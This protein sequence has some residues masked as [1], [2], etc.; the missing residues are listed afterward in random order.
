MEEGCLLPLSLNFSLLFCYLVMSGKNKKKLRRLGLDRKSK[1]QYTPVGHSLILLT[2]DQL[3]QVMDLL[4]L[5]WVREEDEGWEELV[6]DTLGHL[7]VEYGSIDVLVDKVIDFKPCIHQ[8][9]EY[10]AVPI[11]IFH[12]EGSEEV[13][14][15]FTSN[16]EFYKLTTGIRVCED[17]D[18]DKVIEEFSKPE[19]FA[20]VT[21]FNSFQ[22]R[23]DLE[24]LQEVLPTT[25]PDLDQLILLGQLDEMFS[26]LSEEELVPFIQLRQ[27]QP[28]VFRRMYTDQLMTIPTKTGTFY[29]PQKTRIAWSQNVSSHSVKFQSRNGRLGVLVSSYKGGHIYDTFK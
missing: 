25:R 8:R 13:F 18:K 2:R 29:Q 11:S 24:L 7:P 10:P 12:E 14:F 6:R 9:T 17:G 16:V 4:H 19:V 22:L 5:K 21:P 27:E 23:L 15:T 1:N 26:P 20:G 28:E 3:F